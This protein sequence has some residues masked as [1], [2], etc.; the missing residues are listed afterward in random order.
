MEFK[1]IAL[2]AF[3]V[4]GIEG[5]TED[6]PDFVNR[7]WDTANARF[8]E[9]APLARMDES[10]MPRVW[11]L[12]SDQS[13]TFQPW[14]HDFTEGLY[15]AGVEVDQTAVPPTGW[16]KWTSPAYEYA[17][18]P[19]RGPDSFHAALSQLKNQGLTLIGAVYDRIDPATGAT[20]MYFPVHLAATE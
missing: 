6:G 12:M 2:P 5:S 1:T 8:E 9:I 15:L 7:L 10:G 20:W 3:C 18:A 17:V 14:E 19:M 16:T 13:R 4:V 11:G